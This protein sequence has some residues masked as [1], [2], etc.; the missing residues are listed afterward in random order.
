[1]IHSCNPGRNYGDDNKIIIK[2]TGT[3]ETTETTDQIK[4]NTRRRIQVS[5]IQ[6]CHNLQGRCV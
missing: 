6:H 1:M 3:E 2:T 4:R 5:C